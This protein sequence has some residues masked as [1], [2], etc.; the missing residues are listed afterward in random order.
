M[1]HRSDAPSFVYITRGSCPREP[2][3]LEADLTAKKNRAA[4]R[5]PHG[6]KCRLRTLRG[7]GLSCEF[8]RQFRRHIGLDRPIGLRH[9]LDGVG[10]DIDTLRDGARRRRIDH[11]R[12]DAGC[13]RR[14]VLLMACSNANRLAGQECNRCPPSSIRRA[15]PGRKAGCWRQRVS[16]GQRGRG[17]R[18]LRRVRCGFPQ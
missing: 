8:R 16:H 17:R 10:L 1:R 5:A 12:P 4:Q 11:A 9:I 13:H 18:F 15:Q 2:F 6:G 14:A 3:P 7:R